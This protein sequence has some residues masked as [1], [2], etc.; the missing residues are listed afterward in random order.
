MRVIQF[1]STISLCI[2]INIGQTI[3][4]LESTTTDKYRLEIIIVDV[5]SNDKTI[6]VAKASSGIIPII[7]V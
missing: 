4:N 3:R 2:F 5:G 7:F 6:E 1:F